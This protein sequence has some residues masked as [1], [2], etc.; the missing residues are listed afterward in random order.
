MFTFE[1]WDPASVPLSMWPLP[2]ALD[3]PSPSSKACQGR[4]HT[5]T[6]E[7]LLLCDVWRTADAEVEDVGVGVTGRWRWGVE[8]GEGRRSGC[9]TEQVSGLSVNTAC[10]P[11]SP[12]R[13]LSARDQAR[14]VCW[15]MVWYGASPVCG[16]WSQQQ[17]RWRGKNNSTPLLVWWK[18]KKVCFVV[19]IQVDTGGYFN[20]QGVMWY[21]MTITN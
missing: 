2:V 6:F 15:F 21:S 13:D 12:E 20:C 16:L 14:S 7:H 4:S 11:K 17:R 10:Q 18:K 3:D 9:V 19:V 8:T 5:W 1:A